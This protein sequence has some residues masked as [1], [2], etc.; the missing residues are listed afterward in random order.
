L[1]A[2]RSGIESKQPEEWAKSPIL[3]GIR[4]YNEDDCKSTAE[5]LIWLRKVAVEN[6]I[7]TARKVVAA[8]PARQK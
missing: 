3:K 5:L 2:L 1:N 4:D 7:P 6:K 8:A